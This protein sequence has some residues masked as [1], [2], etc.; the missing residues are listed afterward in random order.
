MKSNGN[1]TYYSMDVSTSISHKKNTGNESMRVCTSPSQ[2]YAKRFYS[3]NNLGDDT[4]RFLFPWPGDETADVAYD[5]LASVT[6]ASDVDVSK[7]H[8]HK[9]PPTLGALLAVVDSNPKL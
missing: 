5:K 9:Q 6:P 8:S 2:S 3:S 4:N 1:K 7:T